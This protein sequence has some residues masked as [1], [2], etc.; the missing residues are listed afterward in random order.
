MGTRQEALRC[1]REHVGNRHIGMQT[2]LAEL[3]LELSGGLEEL[4]DLLQQEF[5]VELPEEE[6]LEAETVGD[7]CRLVERVAGEAGRDYD[8]YADPW[9][10]TSP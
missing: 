6:V 5:G 7:L 2:G 4:V 10:E 8:D 1:I 9:L 3:S